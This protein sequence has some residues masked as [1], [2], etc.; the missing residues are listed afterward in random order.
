MNGLEI[1]T[2]L[3]DAV[4]ECE[5]SGDLA[6]RNLGA[7]KD[8]VEQL[9]DEDHSR[10]ILDMTRV[11]Y[12]DSAAL[13]ALIGLVGE[14]RRRGGDIVLAGLSEAIQQFLSIIVRRGPSPLFGIV[15]EDVAAGH[16]H[17]RELNLRL[18]ELLGLD[19]PERLF[20]EANR[21]RREKRLPAA[22][23]LYEQAHELGGLDEKRKRIELAYHRGYCLYALGK[24]TEA[25]PVLRHVIEVR[26]RYSPAHRYL[27]ASLERTG[28][29][30]EAARVLD[31]ACALFPGDDFKLLLQQLRKRDSIPA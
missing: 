1:K 24:Y 12:L 9:L 18:E 16:A 19:D 7:F 20:A 8:G 25:I 27:A 14:A 6:I 23:A 10:V 2:K 5:L 13:G 21:M 31:R 22:L 17:F 3:K 28:E 11:K 15:T 30:G 4:V 29:P 26:A